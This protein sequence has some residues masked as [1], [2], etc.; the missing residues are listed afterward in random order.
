MEKISSRFKDFAA[1]QKVKIVLRQR[2]KLKWVDSATRMIL[3]YVTKS[4]IFLKIIFC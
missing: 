1:A 2:K 3:I 4:E